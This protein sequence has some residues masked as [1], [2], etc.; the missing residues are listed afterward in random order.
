MD[1]LKKNTKNL[2]QDSWYQ[3]RVLNMGFPKFECG[4][5]VQSLSRYGSGVC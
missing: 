5:I 1:G 2:C 4:V 3:G